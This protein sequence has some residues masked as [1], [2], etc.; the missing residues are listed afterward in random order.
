VAFKIFDGKIELATGTYK[1]EVAETS[2]PKEFP[3]RLILGRNVLD[4]I[5]TYIL[6]KRHIICI[7]DP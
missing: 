5:D 6:G 1:I 7:K 3:V 2:M 4:S